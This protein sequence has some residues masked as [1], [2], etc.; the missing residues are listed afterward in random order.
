MSRIS[1]TLDLLRAGR[2]GFRID[3]TMS[4]VHEFEPDCGPPGIHPMEF[5]VTWGARDLVEWLNPN[6]DAFMAVELDGTVT[7]DGLCENTPCSGSLELKYFDEHKIRYNFTFE[8]DAVEYRYVGEKVNIR[9]WNLPVSHTTCFGT[10]TEV[11]SGKLVSK[12]VTHFRMRT[13]PEFATSLR[14][15]VAPRAA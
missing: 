9:P 12:S 7:I 8:V 13:V 10:L 15:A 2:L 14:L 4:G 3:E 11:D 1:K 6:G 5:K